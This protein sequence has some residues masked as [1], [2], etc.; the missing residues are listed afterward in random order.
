MA[1]HRDSDSGDLPTATPKFPLDRA[2]LLLGLF[3]IATVLLV[4]GIHPKGSV[5][6]GGSGASTTTPSVAPTTTTTTRPVPT[7]T[8]APKAVANVPVLVANASG[9]AGAAATISNQLQLAGWTVQQPINASARV[10]TSTVYYVQG[11]KSAA[12]T[13]AK[14]LNL[15]A[16]AA[17]PYTTSAP[18]STI[19]TAELL[20]V[21]GPD[22]ADAGSATGT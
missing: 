4:G 6:S 15:A 2:V 11:Q 7:T 21:V 16:T 3:I 8:T 18:V 22:L 12:Q 13:L 20:V 1:D 14:A 17:E 5:P 9:T 19:G 10:S